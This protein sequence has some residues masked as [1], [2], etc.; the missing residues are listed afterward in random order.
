MDSNNDKVPKPLVALGV[1]GLHSGSET[2]SPR[3]INGLVHES[4]S[5]NELN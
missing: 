3:D 5:K 2:V 4:P 1:T